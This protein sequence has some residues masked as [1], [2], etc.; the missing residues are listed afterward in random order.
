M[1]QCCT[2]YGGLLEKQLMLNRQNPT[3]T[4]VDKAIHRTNITEISGQHRLR[5]FAQQLRSPLSTAVET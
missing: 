3:S 5:L 4:T 1:A 2:R